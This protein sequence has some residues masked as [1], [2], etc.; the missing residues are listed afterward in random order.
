M[1][2]AQTMRNKIVSSLFPSAGAAI[3]VGA[4]LALLAVPPQCAAQNPG[5]RGGAPVA[6]K[7]AAPMDINGYWVSV[8]TQNWRLRMVVPPKGDYMGIAMTPASKEI[9]DAWDP[10]K[11]ETTG[12]QCKGYGAGTIMTNPERLHITWPDDNTLQMEID[13]GTQTRTFHFG[14]WKP[15]AGTKPSWQGESVA[16]WQSRERDG[17][18]DPKA[19]YLQVTTR[20]MLAGYL[21]KN[22]VPYGE[23]AVLIEDYD[24]FQEPTGEQWMIVTTELRDPKYLDRPYILSAQFR[25][26]RDGSKW[27]PTPCSSRW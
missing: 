25:K 20:N 17:R 19:R 26:E 18:R 24:F 6:P 15:E 7:A 8:I 5:G 2:P 13:A 23:N 16:L 22:G 10:A 14:N 4:G 11:D 12:N 3:L 21:R 27:E 1:S 9:A